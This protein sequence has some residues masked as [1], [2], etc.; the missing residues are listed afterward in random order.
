MAGGRYACCPYESPFGAITLAAGDDGLKGLWF[1][2]Q[3]YFAGTLDAPMEPDDNVHL[4]AACDWLDEYFAGG[5]PDIN[6]LTLA[7]IGSEYRLVV[8]QLLREIPLGQVRTYGELADE[9]ARRMGKE[10]GSARAVGG[11]VGHNPISII[12]P[13][14]RV[15]GTGGNLTGFGGGI[16]RKL[17]LLEHEGV[18][19]SGFYVPKFSTAP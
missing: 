15:I 17:Q 19:C 14:H 8:W 3:R 11:A 4:K 6:Q 5:H 2:G 1:D 10:H 9:A 12:V 13:C 18:D 7:P 16:A